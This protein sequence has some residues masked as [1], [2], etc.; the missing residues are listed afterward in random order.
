MTEPKDVLK[1]CPFCGSLEVQPIIDDEPPNI[2]KVGCPGC[3]I[4]IRQKFKRYTREELLPN[5]I[6]AWNT[7]HAEG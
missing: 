7:R 2:V 5:L 4:Y 3:L 1:P 6:E